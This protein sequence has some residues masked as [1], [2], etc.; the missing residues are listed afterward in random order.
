L[1]S[2]VPPDCD[3]QTW[4]TVLMALHARF[5]G[6]SEGLDI[7]EQWSAQG[8]KYRRGEIAVKWRSFR[9]SGVTFASL[10]AIARNHG[11]DLSEI[12]RKHASG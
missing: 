2:H 3:Y 7:A 11:A 9:G 8:A 1:L 12:A 6:S 5:S 4:L 10:P